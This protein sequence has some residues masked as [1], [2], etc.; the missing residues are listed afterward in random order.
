MRMP[1]TQDNKHSASKLLRI[2]AA[3]IHH[4]SVKNILIHLNF[5]TKKVKYLP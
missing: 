5:L 3:K 4:H 1:P 2:V